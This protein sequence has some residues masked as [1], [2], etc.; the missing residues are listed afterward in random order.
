MA[1]PSGDKMPPPELWRRW[2]RDHNIEEPT[3]VEAMRCVEEDG[4][5]VYL[6]LDTEHAQQLRDVC[7]AMSSDGQN[8][9]T[10]LVYRAMSQSPIL[11]FEPHYDV[12]WE[13]SLSMAHRRSLLDLVAVADGVPS[14]IPIAHPIL[15]S[16]TPRAQRRADAYARAAQQLQGQQLQGWNAAIPPVNPPVDIPE[17]AAP[18]PVRPADL[19]PNGAYRGC[20]CG[21]CREVR[22]QEGRRMADAAI[23]EPPR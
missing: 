1:Y 8:E 3:H 6:K 4:E 23:Q 9:V 19:M 5:F 12:L 13:A 16:I 20:N 2:R 21:Q 17:Q 22:E 10:S 18:Y 7:G 14:R 15:L 11:S